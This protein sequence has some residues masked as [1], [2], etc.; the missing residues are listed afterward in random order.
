MSSNA[1]MSSDLPELPELTLG[2]YRH[3]KGGRYEV[4][5][6]ARHSES[7]EPLVVY[8]PL[9][10]DSGCWVRPWSMFVEDVEFE[11]RLQPRF[12]RVD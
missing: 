1:G 10:N 5:A 12:A 3:Y 7:L 2:R 9:D 6:V 8:R 4:L 11:G